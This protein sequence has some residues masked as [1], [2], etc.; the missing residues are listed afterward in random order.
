MLGAEF[1][2]TEGQWPLPSSPS[3]SDLTLVPLCKGLRCLGLEMSA[4]QNLQL[5]PGWEYLHAGV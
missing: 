2:S 3:G 5:E 1:K 4:P